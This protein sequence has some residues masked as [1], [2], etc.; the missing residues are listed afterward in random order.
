M[1]KG[2]YTLFYFE[3]LMILRRTQ[4]WLYPLTFFLMII[5]LLPFAFS[6]DPV[7]LQSLIPGGMWIAA[8]FASLLAITSIFQADYEDGCLQQW[9]LGSIPLPF[10]VLAK[11]AAHWLASTL[12]L[13]I[14]A[15]LIG[16][17]FQLS[18]DVIVVLTISLTVGTPILVL[19]GSL[20][21]ALTLGLRQQGV[22]LSLM[23][24]PLITPVLIFGVN[25]VLQQQA[26]FTAS[27][28]IWL[29]AG[30][31]LLGMT[32]IPFAIAMALRNGL[33]D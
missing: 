17:L 7:I 21:A 15:P 31:L 20:G 30:L 18:W 12:P 33:D 11:L 2:L 23:I 5:C 29:L 14:L 1:L 22:M 10:I 8:L 19:L 16:W 9:I 6:P 26:G 4:E 13:L 32:T 25:M 24:L 28:P 27:G 3:C